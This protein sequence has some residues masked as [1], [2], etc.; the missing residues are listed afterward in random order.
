MSM[1]YLPIT[2]IVFVMDGCMP[3]PNSCEGIEASRCLTTISIC[4]NEKR[5]SFGCRLSLLNEYCKLAVDR[6]ACASRALK[7]TVSECQGDR[8]VNDKCMQRVKDVL[9]DIVK[10][11]SGPGIQPQVCHWL[12]N[13]KMK[14]VDANSTQGKTKSPS[15]DSN[16]DIKDSNESF[17]D[18]DTI[19]YNYDKSQGPETVRVRNGTFK[20]T[21]HDE[22][23]RN[24]TRTVIAFP[25]ERPQ[26]TITMKETAK[27]Q[28]SNSSFVF[29]DSLGAIFS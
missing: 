26:K 21:F 4:A 6:L 14:S 10:T 1:L 3:V 24:R 16:K 12:S 8:D 28:S 9:S 25:S 15:V 11:C 17:E 22:S 7:A 13:D 20:K 19:S 27:S 2:A 23:L 29:N 18:R 5:S